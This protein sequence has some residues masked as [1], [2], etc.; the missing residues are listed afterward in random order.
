MPLFT[1]TAPLALAAVLAALTPTVAQ[2]A[3]PW[4]APIDLPGAVGGSTPLIVT[5]AGH[6]LLATPTRPATPG[7]PADAAS[8]LVALGPD[9][10]PGRATGV[11]DAELHVASYGQDRIVVAGRTA[12]P[13]PGAPGIFS[14]DDHSRVQ[15]AFGTGAGGLGALRS[16]S[17]TSGEQLFALAAGARG[18]VAVVTGRA[19]AGTRKLWVRRPGS[20]SFRVALS[21]KVGSRARGTT[22]AVG[23]KGDLL[24]VWEDNHCIYSRHVGPGG[25]VGKTYRLGAGVQSDLQAA[26]DGTGREH[27]AWKSQRVSEGEA[28]TPA[29][30]SYATAAPGHGFGTAR[31]IESVGK[32]GMGRFVGSPGVRLVADAGDDV[33]LAWTGFD[34]TNYVA[35]AA[36]IAGGHVGPRRQLSPAGADAVLGDLAVDPDGRAV[37]LWRAG[38]AGADPSGAGTHEV[39]WASVRPG[40]TAPFGAPEQVSDAD[41]DVALPPATAIDPATHRALAAYGYVVA[42]TV[43]VSQR[44][45]LG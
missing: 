4:S 14:V 23:P 17:G 26:I 24:L 19:G 3:P 12:R 45:P 28:N 6:A 35:R 31:T 39:V 43:Q 27:V 44:A 21:V 10:T 38:V 32:T 11:P 34:G 7:L 30:V 18:D 9:G 15:V 36:T 37:A 2:A 33:V 5:N 13:A 25:G 1:R 16:L 40:A 20:S 41:K 29:V 8:Q 22:A 42:G